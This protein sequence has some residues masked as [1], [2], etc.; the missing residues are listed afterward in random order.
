MT[1]QET[2]QTLEALSG[3]PLVRTPTAARER[4][5]FLMDRLGID[6]RIPVVHVV[7]TCGKGSTSTFIAAALQAAGHRTG[8]MTGPHLVDYPER[9]TLNGQAVSHED[10]QHH[11]ERTF[12]Y[13]ET[14]LGRPTV[15][16]VVTAAGLDYLQNR[17]DVIVLEAG[18]G[19]GRDC[20][21]AVPA[22]V[23]V[24]TRLGLDHTD[25]M[26]PTLRDIAQEKA[27][28]IRPGIPVV[29]APQAPE[30]GQLLGPQVTVQTPV[31]EAVES[32]L[33]G[34]T[35]RTRDGVWR[36][37]MRGRH[38]ADN[39]ATALAALQILGQVSPA[40]VVPGPAAA[41]GLREASLPGRLQ[42]IEKDPWLIL[43][44][45]HNLDGARA[46][47]EFLRDVGPPRPCHLIL[48]VL[49][50]KNRIAML[51]VLL[52]VADTVAAT[53]PQT[54]RAGAMADWVECVRQQRAGALV[55]DH[56]DA[57]LA[58]RPGVGMTVV[59]G[60]LYLVGEALETLSVPRRT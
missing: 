3:G 18:M 52:P 57:A 22:T 9:V 29:L 41:Q 44:G 42:V 50:D 4:L 43:D 23:T 53:L 5:A 2:I 31:P 24:L 58:H 34:V 6:W 15:L 26:G 60:S 45:A 11:L 20:T 16:E 48:G 7:G 27:R 35:F 13:L 30:A 17:V 1:W 39:A 49:A 37:G 32:N 25:V 28:A 8:L 12:Q 33:E 47:A 59:A 38:Q 21:M 51:E 40:L 14:P 56:V 46:L 19:G 55:F 36:L 54:L 10:L